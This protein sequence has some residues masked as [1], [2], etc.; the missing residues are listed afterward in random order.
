MTLNRLDAGWQLLALKL[1]G[2]V[3]HDAGAPFWRTV[4]SYHQKSRRFRDRTPMA[5][6]KSA[7]TLLSGHISEY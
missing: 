7:E 2:P 1:R 6:A 3:F 5:S 4:E